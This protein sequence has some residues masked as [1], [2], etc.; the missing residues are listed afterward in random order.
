MC[1]HSI[2]DHM[3]INE[4]IS[5]TNKINNSIPIL[6]TNQLNHAQPFHRVTN[7][8]GYY[9]T[10]TSSLRLNAFN[11]ASPLSMNSYSHLFHNPAMNQF[12]VSPIVS[13]PLS[14]LRISTP[15]SDSCSQLLSNL[16]PRCSNVTQ[17]NLIMPNMVDNS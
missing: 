15:H 8:Q 12:T 2:N 17:S 13:L 9:R 5:N 1:G 10:N 4:S 7:H 3:P 14:S 6:E 16:L 11:H